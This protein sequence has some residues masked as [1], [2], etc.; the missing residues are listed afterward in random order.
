[1][2]LANWLASFV[3]TG[4]ATVGV[5]GAEVDGGVADGS[6]GEVV[7]EHHRERPCQ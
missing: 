7:V 3:V 2:A 4:Q 5:L 1:M 6:L